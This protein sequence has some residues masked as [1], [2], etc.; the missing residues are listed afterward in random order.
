MLE[1][2]YDPNLPFDMGSR[3]DLF[4]S[5]P[6]PTWPALAV[7]D[8]DADGQ[9]E[10]EV[11]LFRDSDGNTGSHPRVRIGRVEMGASPTVD[12]YLDETWTGGVYGTDRVPALA[13]VD[14]DADGM[15]LAFTGLVQ[16]KLFDPIPLVVMCAPPVKAD[17][18]QNLD[19]SEVAF[20][21]GQAS[22][23]T[24]GVTTG[25]TATASVAAGFDVA[26]LFGVEAKATVELAVERSQETTE[27]INLVQGYRGAADADVVLF[28]GTLYMSYEYVILS[29]LDPNA[30]GQYITL[31]FPVA[32]KL[33]KW[34]VPYYNSAVPPQFQIETSVL[35]HVPGDPSTYPTRTEM[36]A[37]IGDDMKWLLPN[38]LPVGQGSGSSYQRIEFEQ[39]ITSST[40]T[41]WSYGGSVSSNTAGLTLETST[42]WSE[43]S[44]YGISL[45]N[46]S[47]FEAAVG[48][49]ADPTEYQQWNYDWGIAV[50]SVGR[51]ANA[52]TN[53]PVDLM[54]D[55]HCYQVI[56]Y[57]VE[58][59]G[60]AW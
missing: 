54:P 26:D 31:D 52:T 51:R 6:S 11:L 36:L 3:T 13:A 7:G 49:I 57:W 14:W 33:Y 40:Q 5:S 24:W 9:V 37:D 60:S 1:A 55:R 12:W 35:T 10:L 4:V 29:A 38:A 39:E 44:M 30:V 22:G 16:P 20:E 17:I 58:P 45:S 46:T 50:Q 15:A 32:E 56:R 42:M 48:D 27:R 18:G 23:Q 43:G 53:L 2:W 21:T 8:A 34:T 28:Q 25:I 41:T 59:T 47:V 19:D